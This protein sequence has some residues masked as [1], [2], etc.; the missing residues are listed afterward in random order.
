MP[1]AA[2]LIFAKITAS[3]IPLDIM[4]KTDL[5][6]RAQNLVQQLAD[7]CE[8]NDFGS[9]TVSIYDTA[10]VSMVTKR[11]KGQDQWLFPE[12][13][14]YILDTQ[15]PDGSWDS[16]TSLEDGILN[17]MAALLALKKHTSTLPATNGTSSPD[18]GDMITKAKKSLD[19][20]LY[21]WDVETCVNVGVEILVPAILAMLET[22]GV[23]FRFPGQPRLQAVREEKMAKLNPHIL[24][25][26]PTTFHHSLEAFI[27]V[28][29]FDRLSQ[30]KTL[31]GMMGSPASTA[32]YLI[33]SSLWDAEAE[34]Y[35][36]RVVLKGQGEGSGGVPTVFPTPLFEIAWVWNEYL[37]KIDQDF[38]QI[39]GGLHAFPSQH[40]S[41]VHEAA[42]LV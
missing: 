37:T 41:R 19:S 25:D 39:L 16:H 6:R 38:D 4:E 10:W 32:S 34:A 24:Y 8:S 7:G 30:H 28:I 29:D 13:F 15:L 26:T 18:L 23:Y 33:H 31:G 3:K 36:A 17:T 42:A 12:S 11:I 5:I 40:L 27:G 35:L 1:S 2:L 14:Q 20:R 21:H 22:E 9:A